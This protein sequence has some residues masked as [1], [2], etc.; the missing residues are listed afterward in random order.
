MFQTMDINMDVMR[1][2]ASMQLDSNKEGKVMTLADRLRKE[3]RIEGKMEGEVLGRHAVLQRQLGK[4]FGKDILDIRMQDRLRS[5][6][7]EQLDLWAERILDATT[8]EDVFRE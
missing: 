5:A 4:R 8:I 7:A 1:N 3:G 2:I 6:S